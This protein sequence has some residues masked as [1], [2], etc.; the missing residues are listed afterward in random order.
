MHPCTFSIIIGL[1]KY[2][3]KFHIVVGNLT[4]VFVQLLVYNIHFV[5]SG[6]DYAIFLIAS[7]KK[8]HI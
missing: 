3:S 1:Q 4:K 7:S 8:F 6:C 5:C 2:F